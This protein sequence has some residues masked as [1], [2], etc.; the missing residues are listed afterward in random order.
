MQKR[1]DSVRRNAIEEERNRCRHRERGEQVAKVDRKLTMEEGL[2]PIGEPNKK[3]RKSQRQLKSLRER[4]SK[5][6]G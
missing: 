1:D 3:R 4:M 5:H 2:V 6:T